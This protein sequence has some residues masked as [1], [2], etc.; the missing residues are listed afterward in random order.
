MGATNHIQV[1]DW[2]YD[3]YAELQTDPTFVAEQL[4]L[5]IVVQIATV[6]EDE[7]IVQKELAE[8]LDISPSA[9]SQLLSGQ[10]NVSLKRLVKVALALGMRWDVPKLIPFESPH[11]ERVEEATVRI[12]IGELE[13]GIGTKGFSS[14]SKRWGQQPSQ[15][16]SL[17]I[18][19][20]PIDEAFDNEEQLIAA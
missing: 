18:E 14:G 11:I 20:E 2:L 6:M 9:M 19:G 8:E 1:A 17:S 10:Q 5:D 16:T 15:P 12:G 13:A 4:I 7:G 3:D